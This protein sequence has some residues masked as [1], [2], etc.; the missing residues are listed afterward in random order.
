MI[1]GAQYPGNRPVCTRPIRDG[2]A[3]DW[4]AAPGS[5][6]SMPPANGGLPAASPDARSSICGRILAGSRAAGMD[7]FIA[8]ITRTTIFA[9][10]GR[11]ELARVAGKVDQ[12]PVAAATVIIRQGDA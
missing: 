7:Q 3:C 9:N 1:G 4:P 2:L 8:T 6:L 12:V 5:T 10:L 11:E